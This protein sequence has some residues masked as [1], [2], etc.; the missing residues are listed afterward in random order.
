M[1]PVKRKAE[2]KSFQVKGSTGAKTYGG[3]NLGA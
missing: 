2:E 3:N 1:R